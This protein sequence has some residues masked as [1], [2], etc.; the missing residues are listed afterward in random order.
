MPACKPFIFGQITLK[1]TLKKILSG[2]NLLVWV[3]NPREL[4]LN[5]R[6][7]FLLILI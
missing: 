2:I 7:S 1:N 4:L 6:D 5:H 3:A